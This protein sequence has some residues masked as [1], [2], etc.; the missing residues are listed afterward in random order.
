[1]LY[2]GHSYLFTYVLDMKILEL[3]CFFLMTK[4]F[5]K[6]DVGVLTW[7]GNLFESKADQ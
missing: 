7:Q 3:P 5:L 4:A 2:L 1:M 6:Q